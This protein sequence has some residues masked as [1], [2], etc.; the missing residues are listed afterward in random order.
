MKALEA[1]PVAASLPVVLAPVV[2]TATVLVV[3]VPSDLEPSGL[4]SPGYT[5]GLISSGGTMTV[6]LATAVS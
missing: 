3:F 6:L 2:A 5:S 1:A 4:V